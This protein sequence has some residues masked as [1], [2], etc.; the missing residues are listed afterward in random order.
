MKL[1]CNWLAYSDY[2]QNTMRFSFCFCVWW[3]DLML[4]YLFLCIYYLCF[5]IRKINFCKVHISMK[6]VI[7]WHVQ[8]TRWSS[9]IITDKFWTSF[10]KKK[11]NLWKSILWKFWIEFRLYINVYNRKCLQISLFNFT[12]MFFRCFLWTFTK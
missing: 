7:S 1:V 2:C 8:F 9:W 6:K 11:T 4:Y 5:F 3:K 12:E 10:F